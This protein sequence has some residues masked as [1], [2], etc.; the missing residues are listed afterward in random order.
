MP[1]ISLLGGGSFSGPALT[2]LAA[3]GPALFAWWSGGQLL[4]K[5]DDPALPELLAGRRRANVRAISI[6]VVVMIMFGGASAVWGIPLLIAAMIAVRYPLRT[7]L[8]GETWGFGAYLWHTAISVA[9]G[10][11]FWIALAYAPSL[12]RR[13]MEGTG[14]E[15]RWPAVVPATALA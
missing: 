14:G 7:R 9:G 5:R 8:L 3:L 11:G 2:L 6:A 10:F 12:V 13:V 15:R 1:P 4:Q